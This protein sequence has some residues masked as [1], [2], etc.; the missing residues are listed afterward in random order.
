MAL[1][2]S[3]SKS[4]MLG[5]HHGFIKSKER[6]ESAPLLMNKQIKSAIKGSKGP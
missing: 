6:A 5:G 2:T 4:T 1:A 3:Q